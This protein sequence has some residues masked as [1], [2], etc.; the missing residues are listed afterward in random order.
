MSEQVSVEMDLD[1]MK[2]VWKLHT[3]ENFEEYLKSLGVLY[4]LRKIANLA[5][6]TMT[7]TIEGDLFSFKSE[8]TFRTVELSCT[9]GEEFDNETPDGRKCKAIL[10]L[11]DGKLIQTQKWE[12]KTGTI[13][14]YVDEEGDLI[15]LNE[16]NGIVC[17]RVYKR[18]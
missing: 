9:I 3:S 2:G 10:E 7:I 16:V 14:R 5:R 18:I 6:P 8:S 17:R 15:I 4:P 11:V 13:T 1:K 12:D